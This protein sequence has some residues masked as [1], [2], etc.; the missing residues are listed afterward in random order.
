MQN[1]Y[2]NAGVFFSESTLEGQMCDIFVR[3]VVVEREVNDFWLT[4][5]P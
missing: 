1:T 5:R 3:V 2:A 4:F